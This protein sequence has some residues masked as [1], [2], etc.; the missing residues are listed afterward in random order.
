MKNGF[1]WFVS[2][3]IMIWG[4]ASLASEDASSSMRRMPSD[5]PIGT[6]AKII[7]ESNG[8]PLYT[9]EVTSRVYM[10]DRIMKSMQGPTNVY[11]IKLLPNVKPPEVLWIIGYRAMMTQRDGSTP[12]LP[13]FM[14]HSNLLVRD[15][16]KY[17]KRFPSRLKLFADRLFALD[18]GSQSVQFPVGMGS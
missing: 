14:C 2:A 3:A 1:V 15:G 10:I 8:A 5:R 7:G 12:S 4:N 13:E 17:A 6:P 18:Q 9:L 16:E 11:W